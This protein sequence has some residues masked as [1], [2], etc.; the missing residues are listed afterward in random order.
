MNVPLLMLIGENESF[1]ANT[2]QSQAVIQQ[3]Q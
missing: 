1:Q 2:L 3:T